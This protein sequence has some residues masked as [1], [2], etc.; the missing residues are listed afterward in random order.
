ML[1]Q[2]QEDYLVRLQRHA[3]RICFAYD[4][5]DEEWKDH[6]NIST[7]KERRIRKCDSFIMKVAANPLFGPL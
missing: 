4:R 1:T 2:G 5:P 6:F 3:L 7:L